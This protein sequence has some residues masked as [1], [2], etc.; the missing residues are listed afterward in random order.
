MKPLGP[1]VKKCFTALRLEASG[2]EPHQRAD[3][4][5]VP[6]LVEV[7]YMSVDQGLDVFLDGNAADVDHHLVLGSHG[8]RPPTTAERSCDGTAAVVTS[9]RMDDNHRDPGEEY[10]LA[11]PTRG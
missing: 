11:A 2:D 5:G 3:D 9:L 8:D 6:R 1:S 10:L 4:H 7:F